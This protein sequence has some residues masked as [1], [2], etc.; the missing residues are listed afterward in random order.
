MKKGIKGLT[1]TFDSFDAVLV[2]ELK[3]IIQG[4]LDNPWEGHHDYKERLKDVD[5]FFRVLSW[6][7]KSKEYKE[8][9]EGLK[10][11]YDDLVGKAFPN[12][13]VP[14]WEYYNG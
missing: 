10:P 2:G 13:T 9:F 4:I 6:Y 11:M 7:T 3:D 12:P 1:V 8:Y 5:G 14:G